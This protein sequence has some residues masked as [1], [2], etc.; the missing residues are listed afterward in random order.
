MSIPQQG[1]WCYFYCIPPIWWWVYHSGFVMLFFWIPPMWWWVST[2]RSVM[3]FNW[4]PPTWR[5]VY[6]S[7]FSDV[8]FP[9]STHNKVKSIPHKFSD[10]C[11]TITPINFSFCS[12]MFRQWSKYLPYK[13]RQRLFLGK[14]ILVLGYNVKCLKRICYIRFYSSEV[15]HHSERA[16]YSSFSGIR[17]VCPFLNKRRSARNDPDKIAIMEPTKYEW[18]L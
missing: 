13:Y 8:I 11:L 6:H 15:L 17:K 3:S 4:I 1:L 14:S 12:A 7:G 16:F 18:L 2:V 10:D 9:G 5:R